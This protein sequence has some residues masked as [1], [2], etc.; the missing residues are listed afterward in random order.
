ML[1]AN[2]TS[3]GLAAGVAFDEPGLMGRKIF[4]FV[5]SHGY[6][7]P[8]DGFGYRGTRLN[9]TPGTSAV[10]K[11]DRLNIAVEAIT[12]RPLKNFLVFIVLIL[13]KIMGLLCQNTTVRIDTSYRLI[14]SHAR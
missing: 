1:A 9:T 3:R 4:F 7:F 2:M 14:R 6:E 10:I 8:K 11:V 13:K 12:A 5:E